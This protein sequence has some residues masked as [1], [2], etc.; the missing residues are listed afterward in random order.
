[1]EKNQPYRHVRAGFNRAAFTLIELLVVIAI[2]A[3][4]AALLLPV[5]SAAK[6]KA[7]SISCLNNLKQLQL[8]W[9]MYADDNTDRMTHNWP[10]SAE[11]W[12]TGWMAGAPQ[13]FDP[14]DVSAGKLYPYN[15][16]LDI[17]RCPS[18]R[19]LPATVRSTPGAQSK[20]PIV[21]NYSMSGRMGGADT[22]DAQQYHVADTSSILGPNYPQFKRVGDV[23]Q[24]PV[25][26]AIVFVDESIN[27][28]DDGFF[29]VQLTSIWQNSPTVRH[30]QGGQFSFADGHAERWHWR[31]LNQ[32]QSWDAPS[33]GASGNTVAD[34]IRLQQAVATP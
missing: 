21:R 6:A 13:A 7:Q 9:T 22:S 29:A 31:V 32:D 12:I 18:V 16:S 1:M 19:Q 23:S 14:T 11:A 4:L 24:P 2:I 15:K 26:Q 17:Y 28:I 30:S 25:S 20:G 8:C 5:L 34:L 27:T 3:I 33:T 10:G